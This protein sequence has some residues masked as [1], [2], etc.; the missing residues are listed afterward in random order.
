[1]E[2]LLYKNK[3]RKNLDEII[4][5][6]YNDILK[7]NMSNTSR[8]LSM[9]LPIVIQNGG[10][11]F[12]YAKNN[13]L[14]RT[15]VFVQSDIDKNNLDRIH[16]AFELGGWSCSAAGGYYDDSRLRKYLEDAVEEN[17]FGKGYNEYNISVLIFEPNKNEIADDE[18]ISNELK[19]SNSNYKF[20]LRKGIFYHITVYKY[21]NKILKQGLVPKNG[22]EI[23]RSRNTNDR[24]YL[25]TVPDFDSD[26]FDNEYDEDINDTPVMLKID[27]SK[28]N[29]PI[30]L[31]KDESYSNAVYTTENIPPYCIT[32]LNGKN[33]E[34]FKY[35]LEFY[36]RILNYNASKM[37]WSIKNVINTFK[38]NRP[39]YNQV[40]NMI[41]KEI[42]NK[43]KDNQSIDKII[44]QI[45][46]EYNGK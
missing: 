28:M 22:N 45:I 42:T 19:D 43:Y 13:D 9:I 29:R 25:S 38:S 10:R 1:M 27:L 34:I 16:Q 4:D 14:T 15:E 26:Y 30:T 2:F 18:Y 31:Y 17:L 3:M 11:V 39:M 32:V 5:K 40:F 37:G 7:E 41:K 8:P 36:K 20:T 24:V 46:E 33:I 6:T 23:T 12:D 21:L 44:S 35:G